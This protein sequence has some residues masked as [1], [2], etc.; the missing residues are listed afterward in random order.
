MEHD[1]CVTIVLVYAVNMLICTESGHDGGSLLHCSVVTSWES[2]AGA[3]KNIYVFQKKWLSSKSSQS[4][5]LLA[6]LF[7]CIHVDHWN[8]HQKITVARILGH[9]EERAS[10][11]PEL[12]RPFSGAGKNSQI[13]SNYIG[14]TAKPRNCCKKNL[15][16]FLFSFYVRFVFVLVFFSSIVFFFVF[17]FD[18]CR[19]FF[20]FF[21]QIWQKQ[22]NAKNIVFQ[23]FFFVFCFFFWFMFVFFIFHF[24]GI[25][26][27]P[28]N[29]FNLF[30]NPEN[31]FRFIWGAFK[32]V[33]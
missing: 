23:F 31:N 8:F 27:E 9:G 22:K 4:L 25:I 14:K 33:K 6:Q 5:R 7:L 13:A 19:F 16:F 29:M 10:R 24:F 15:V 32:K 20:P 3:H 11:T 28:K 2:Q 26:F 21:D 18:S 17:V 1:N 12:L 30:S